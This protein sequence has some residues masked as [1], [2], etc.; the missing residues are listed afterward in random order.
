[1]QNRLL[2]KISKKMIMRD[3]YFLF[4]NKSYPY[5]KIADKL[6]KYIR[7]IWYFETVIRY[8]MNAREEIDLQELARIASRVSS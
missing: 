6:L 8:I 3:I 2:R 7:A 5:M 4:E 1:M